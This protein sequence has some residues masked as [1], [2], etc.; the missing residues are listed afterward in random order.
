[1]KQKSQ[2]LINMTKK[3]TTTVPDIEPYTGAGKKEKI[4]VHQYDLKG[5]YIKTFPSMFEAEKELK[6]S[7]GSIS[8]CLS[9]KA[10]SAGGW[11]WRRA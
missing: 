8:L 2:N 6:I 4:A 11:Q 1:M 5:H 7:V 10:K 3:E 9:G